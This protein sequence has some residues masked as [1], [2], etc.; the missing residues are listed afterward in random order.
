VRAL[1]LGNAGDDDA[2]YV[3]EV[4]DGLGATL[5]TALRE[6][7]GTLPDLDGFDAV[8]SLGSEWSVYWAQVADAVARESAL[9]RTAAEGGRPVLGLCFGGQ[10]LAHALGGTVEPAPRPEIGWYTVDTDVPDLLPT[11]PYV[12]WHSDRFVPPPGATELARSPVGAQAY[13]VGR[14][15]GL[16][17]HPEATA[18]M[19]TRWVAGGRDELAAVGTDADAFVAECDRREPEARER[20]RVVVETFLS[21]ALVG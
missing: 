12:Q 19:V 8:V 11:G 20:A 17:F 15:L 2:G 7:G 18:A 4:L 13:V 14:S 6:E 16:Q 21:G 10:L 9:L 5:V 3:S 1:V